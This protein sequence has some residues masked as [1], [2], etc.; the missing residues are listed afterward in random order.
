MRRTS[1]A[2]PRVFT[3]LAFAWALCLPAA[4]IAAQFDYFIKLPP[5]EGDSGKGESHGGEIEI[6]SFSWGASQAGFG[7]GGGGGAGKVNVHDISMSRWPAAG[8]IVGIEPAYDASGESKAAGTAGKDMVMKGSKISEN[9]PAGEAKRLPGKRTP[10]TV[11]LKRGATAEEAAAGGVR[12]AVGDV[13]GDGSAGVA[14][15][16]PKELSI[17][18][19]VPWNAGQPAPIGSVTVRG[20]FPGCRVGARYSNLELGARAARYTLQDV[21]VTSCRAASGEALPMEEVS[22]NYAK[23]KT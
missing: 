3:R 1:R 13:T 11:T 23:I 9:A 7:H 10:P 6:H 17:T 22:F 8:E 21:V 20:K 4:A 15:F 2:M 18:K 19:K 14:Q 5:I 16:N 12:V